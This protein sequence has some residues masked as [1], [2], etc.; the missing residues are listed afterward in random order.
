MAQTIFERLRV[1]HTEGQPLSELIAE[2]CD[3]GDEL[4]SALQQFVNGVRT[5]MIDS[6]ADDILSGVTL[7]AERAIA[8]A[9]ATNGDTPDN[10]ARKSAA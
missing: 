10:G 2:A 6:P 9:Y 4:V 1:Y 7:R 5:H 8:R 3:V